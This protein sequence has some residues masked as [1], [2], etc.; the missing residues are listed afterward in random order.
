V[1]YDNHISICYRSLSTANLVVIM[2]SATIHNEP[3]H[4]P[5]WKR[6]GLKLKSQAA[7]EP[8]PEL[9]SPIESPKR[10]RID[11][12][13]EGPG[14]KTKKT[15]QA[16]LSPA[17]V[18]PLLVRKK[19]VTFTPET[20]ADD[21]DSIK[22]LFNSWVAEQKSRDPFFQLQIS[23]PAFKTPEASIVEEQVSTDLDEKDRRAKRI[24]KPKQEKDKEKPKS[25][26]PSKIVKPANLS[27]RPYLQYLRQYHDSR[28]TWKFNKN[29]QTHLLKHVFDIDI[30]PSDHAHLIC[31]Y[32]RGLQGSVR[33][34]LRDAALA[35]KV[36]D[37]EEGAA[38]FPKDMAESD[39]KQQEYDAAM[40][41]YVESMT[42]AN[43]SSTMGYEEGVLL[44]LSD[45]NMAK[46]VAKRT[47]AEQI[48]GELE[49]G[50][51]VSE[52]ADKGTFNGDNDSQKR[53]RMNDGSTQKVARRRKQRTATV[54]DNPSSS[55]SDDSEDDSSDD[56][57]TE[58]DGGDDTSSSSSSSSSDSE[59]EEDD[60]EDDSD[61]SSGDSEDNDGD[62]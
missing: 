43:A 28:V 36:K 32:V 13:D 41:K 59:S 45:A 54:E 20:K 31:P 40:K 33:T 10:K 55:E 53:L 42:A 9:S 4:I 22:Q 12:V 15:S 16:P 60:S 34:R 48:L 23:Q 1:A 62:E 11:T 46:R 35:I 49:A 61:G 47:R 3:A 50:G 27:S 2:L 58:N 14:K 18:T 51:D 52:V 19:S 57:V 29:H 26:K 8:A 37:Q 56:S 38:G 5:A 44:G 7:S 25:E 17:P 6:L 24:K 39:K 21:G 30:I